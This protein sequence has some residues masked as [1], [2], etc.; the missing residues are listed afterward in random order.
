MNKRLLIL[1]CVF[2][3]LTFISSLMC[4]LL[5]YFNE[6]ERTNINGQEVLASNNVYKSSSIIY[7]QNNQIK[8]EN[9]TPGYSTTYSF[10][11]TNNNADLLK[12]N[13]EWDNVSSTWEVPNETLIP[14]PSE[15]TYYIECSNG[16]KVDKKKMPTNSDEYIIMKDL[17][18]KAK[19]TISC[20]MKIEFVK[21]DIDQ[22]YN[23][24]KSFVGT[25]KIKLSK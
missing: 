7:N 3:V 15:F 25:Y 5:V 21:K 22:T 23:L 10:S 14:N 8:I 11:I 2:S 24:N 16:T 13:V 20:S 9:P 12:Y 1:T 17:E 6:R 18:V 19:D 4:S